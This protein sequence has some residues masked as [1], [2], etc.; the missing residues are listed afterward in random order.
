VV[1]GAKLQEQALEV[2]KRLLDGDP[3]ASLD[4]TDLLLDPLVKRLRAR[5]PGLPY[6]EACE[7]AAVEVFVTYLQA[8]DRYDPTRSALLTW[9]TM[10]AHGDLLNDHASPQKAFER[11]WLVESALSPDSDVGDAPVLGDQNPWFDAV[12]SHNASAVLAAIREAFP[13]ERD[14]WLIWLV[15]VEGSRSTDEAAAVLGLM[16]LPPA[17]R[18]K[19]VRRHK[20]RVMRRLRRLGLDKHDE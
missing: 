19:E 3:T 8:P 9:L 16:D 18:T 6:A 20:D 5:W 11:A 15:C 17:A 12:P 4:A 13:E 2:H 7:D 1:A 14:R 10:Q